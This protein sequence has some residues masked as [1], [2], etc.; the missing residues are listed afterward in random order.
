MTVSSCACLGTGSTL[1]AWQA[2]LRV[3]AAGRGGAAGARKKRSANCEH[4]RSLKNGRIAGARLLSP[5]TWVGARSGRGCGSL[6][7]S[8]LSLFLQ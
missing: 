4:R 5:G 3:G 7:G 2:E 8:L 1:L 6:G